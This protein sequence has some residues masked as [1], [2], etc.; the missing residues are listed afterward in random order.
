MP[1]SDV[2]THMSVFSSLQ[3]DHYVCILL[4]CTWMPWLAWSVIWPSF[5]C[6]WTHCLSLC[7]CTGFWR[8]L[9]LQA[10][11]RGKEGSVWT[12]GDTHQTAKRTTGKTVVSSHTAHCSNACWQQKAKRQIGLHTEECVYHRRK[13]C[14]HQWQLVKVCILC[15]PHWSLHLSPWPVQR[16]HIAVN[17]Q[18]KPSQTAQ[19]GLAF[20]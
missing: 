15:S 14:Q 12:Q 2:Q 4:M 7:V 20:S 17:M 9:S 11:C 6:R 10:S 18:N 3:N 8:L 16:Y 1:V 5:H 13:G 19:L